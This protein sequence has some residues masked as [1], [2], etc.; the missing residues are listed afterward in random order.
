M[1][2][3]DIKEYFEKN[4]QQAILFSVA[5]G[6]LLI[7]V[8]WGVVKLFTGGGETQVA[9]GGGLAPSPFSATPGGPPGMMPGGP[10]GPPMPGGPPG[11]MG[12]SGRPSMP[13]GPPMPM[14]GPSGAPV[15]DAAPS[16]GAQTLDGSPSAGAQSLDPNQ[17]PS[18]GTG[19]RTAPKAK[20]D[21]LK[22]LYT[23]RPDPFAPAGM[24]TPAEMRK[25]RA[26]YI[27]RLEEARQQA[28]MAALPVGLSLWRPKSLVANN[29]ISVDP[30]AQ[31]TPV[32]RRVAGLLYGDRVLGVLETDGKTSVVKP[33]D[34]LTSGP[35][36]VKVTRI[37]RDGIV[38]KK[39]NSK[40]PGTIRVPIKGAPE[41]AA[42]TGMPPM[43]GAPYGRRGGFPGGPPM[44]PRPGGPPLPM[45]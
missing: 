40:N 3:F 15:S 17:A 12:P 35:D 38:L 30:S 11:P 36:R 14:A 18:G 27:A 6:L 21:N 25:R 28:E 26:D 19:G 22:S 16:Q 20:K 5:G 2:K 42:A 24:A 7:L 8:L 32:V 39:L 9:A 10:P 45:E 43:G 4:R 33:G 13:G 44:G 34:V 1:A 37:D 31:Q 41:G 23:P 29:T